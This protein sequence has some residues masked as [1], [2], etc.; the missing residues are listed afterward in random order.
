[1]ENNLKN[2]FYNKC[3]ED[4]ESIYKKINK[5]LPDLASW[6]LEQSVIFE[7]DK[8][9]L[10]KAITDDK[11]EKIGH[12]ITIDVMEDKMYSYKLISLENNLELTKT[13]SQDNQLALEKTSVSLNEENIKRDCSYHIDNEISNYQETYNLKDKTRNITT[14]IS[15]IDFFPIRNLEEIMFD[16]K[17]DFTIKKNN[18]KKRKMKMKI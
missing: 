8:K 10:C 16:I 4:I 11:N 15:Y 12:Q 18:T 14:D 13:Y 17:Q 3:K 2:D 5:Y 6:Q 1:M 9:I 7:K